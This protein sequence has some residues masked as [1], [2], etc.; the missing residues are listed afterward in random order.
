[1]KKVLDRH[2]N[3]SGKICHRRGDNRLIAARRGLWRSYAKRLLAEILCGVFAAE[4]LLPYDLS[5]PEAEKASVGMSSIDDLAE[6]FQASVTATGSR[7]VAVVSS[8]VAFVLYERGRCGPYHGQSY[9]SMRRHGFRLAST[10]RKVPSR[11]RCAKASPQGAKTRSTPAIGSVSGSVVEPWWK[12]C[13]TCLNGI[14]H[15]RC[16]GLKTTKFGPELP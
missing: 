9:L 1:M 2:G 10:S 7:Y 5:H 4:P 3:P 13:G 11:I 6:R 16:S 12:K 15:F 8:S 14:R